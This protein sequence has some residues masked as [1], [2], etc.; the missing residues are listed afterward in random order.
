MRPCIGLKC[1]PGGGL[2]RVEGGL[3][4]GQ[5]ASVAALG[6]RFRP[7]T[8]R[9]ARC[10]ARQTAEL[11]KRQEE[12][13]TDNESVGE[14]PT[15][16][17]KVLIPPGLSAGGGGGSGAGGIDADDRGIAEMGGGEPRGGQGGETATGTS[18]TTRDA[19]LDGC[20]EDSDRVGEGHGIEEE[21]PS[22]RSLAGGAAITCL[23]DG[24]DAPAVWQFVHRG[25]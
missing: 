16:E 3:T 6:I 14:R 24:D 25:G 13:S 2:I 17:E 5:A 1:R 20:E 11:E 10:L 23:P 7:V 18:G 4:A 8:P 21:G 15:Q 12:A 19:S 9:A 22:D